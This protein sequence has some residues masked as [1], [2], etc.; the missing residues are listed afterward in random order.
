VISSD[1]AQELASELSFTIVDALLAQARQ[2]S[3]R[4]GFTLHDQQGPGLPLSYG[5]LFSRSLG[6]AT[7]LKSRGLRQ[8]DRVIICLPTDVDILASIFGVLLAGGV[9][10]PV[11]PPRPQHNLDHWR[12]QV[13]SIARIA[14]PRGAIVSSLLRLPISASLEQHGPN[15]F[16]LTPEG[17]Q[18]NGALE[19]PRI[20]AEDLAFIQFTSGTTQEPKGVAISHAALMANIQG[21]SAAME[22]SEKDISISWLP[23]YHDMGLV[24]HIFVPLVSGVHQHLMSPLH[25]L[26]EPRRWLALLS[27]C[28]ATQTTAPNFAYSMCLGR[29]PPADRRHLDLG[30]L[31]WALNG[32]ETVQRE[33]MEQFCAA[34]GA[35]GFRPEAFRP[36]YGLAEMTL[37]ATFGPV[38]EPLIDW[39]DRNLLATTSLARSAP[40]RSSSAKDFVSVGK[41]L[42]GCEL[43]IAQKENAGND[44]GER[45]VGEILLR[46]P[47]LMTGYFN[48]PQAT[49]TALQ[50]G[51]LHTGDLGYVANGMLFVT[52]RSKDI[53]IKRGRNYLPQDF[54]AGCQDFPELRKGRAIAFGIPNKQSGTEDII[55]LAEVKKRAQLK[56]LQLQERVAA[57]ISER[58]GQKPDRVVLCRP[59]ALPKTTSGKL[60]RQKAK[61]AYV[62]GETP[63]SQPRPMFGMVSL[64]ARSLLAFTLVRAKRFLGWQ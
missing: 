54:E 17:F 8:G 51:W 5:E 64:Q 62:Q 23:P 29:V 44:C 52:G 10:V 26:E 2:R 16:V 1:I 47:S 60:Q 30:A 6:V 43:R 27:S 31:R 59:G 39:V 55:L 7:S 36:V 34:Y 12:Q 61:Q 19:P 58:I 15:L 46:G 45:Q 9:C 56:D 33:T 48:N 50:G 20:F 18:K 63:Q 53:I 40:G 21:L 28:H 32:A 42:P 13:A 14:Q 37:A 35:C 38:G 57:A 4:T 25:F 24:G 49:W 41:P 11:Y 22:L 3:S